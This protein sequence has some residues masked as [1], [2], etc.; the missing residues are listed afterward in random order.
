MKG[1]N[2]IVAA[3]V[4]SLPSCV[5]INPDFYLDTQPESTTAS[6]DEGTT[7][8]PTDVP[9]ASPPTCEPSDA[10]VFCSDFERGGAELWDD[11]DE[12]PDEDNVLVV[13]P[14][15]R[16]APGN[17]VMRLRPPPGPG[18]VDL[19]KI[20]PG[21]YDEL[22]TRW[23]VKYEN[24]Y[25]FEHGSLGSGLH[26]GGR[27]LLGASDIRPEGDDRFSVLQSIPAATSRLTALLDYR[28][29]YQDCTTPETCYRD[30]LPCLAD[31]TICTNPAH[32]ATAEPPTPLRNGEWYCV[33]MH[34]NAGTPLA[35]GAAA[36]GTV[37][38]W[39]D[40]ALV[41]RWDDLWLRTDADLKLGIL[42]ILLYHGGEHGDEG[43]LYD[44][45]V[46]SRERVGCL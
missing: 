23:Y 14:G 27:A 1:R 29:M 44:D 7:A 37:A 22:Y 33:E 26:A 2:Q 5:E 17:H 39:I 24:G 32:R 8:A 13:D 34:V 16:N 6:H 40:G 28:G 20:L 41:G 36:D 31:D 45:I 11:Y 30:R 4:L 15:P 3:L 46:V 9:V 43:V 35:D 21:Y 12:N 10:V 19:V 42:W 18:G 25:D 38:M